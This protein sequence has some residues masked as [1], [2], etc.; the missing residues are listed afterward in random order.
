MY[1]FLSNLSFTDICISSTTI[2]KMLVNIQ[3]KSQSISYTSCFTHITLVV[4]FVNLENFL[5]A[6][7][8]YDRYVAIC[9][10][11]RYM[12]IMSPRLFALL[13]LLSLLVSIGDGQIH[14]LRAL[15]LSFCTDLEIPHFF[16]E[17][18]QVIKIACSDTVIDNILIYVSI[19]IVGG[20]TLGGIIFSYIRIVSSVSGMP[21]RGKV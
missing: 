5:L 17:L 10:P 20:I 11:L 19:C 2:P 13:V 15:Q 14:T 3:T 21:S 7:M 12:D 1:F 16:C 4:I 8:A 9:H 6:V 18:A